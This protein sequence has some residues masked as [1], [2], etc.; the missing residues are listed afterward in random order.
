MH[1]WLRWATSCQP[2]FRN[3]ENDPAVSSSL[4]ALNASQANPYDITDKAKHV[5]DD[6]DGD[7]GE[8]QEEE[9]DDDHALMQGVVHKAPQV[10]YSAFTLLLEAFGNALTEMPE[11]SQQAIASHFLLDSAQ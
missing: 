9:G 2:L 6:Q 8:N 11:D 5:D 3:L 1:C 4:P 7:V 10:H